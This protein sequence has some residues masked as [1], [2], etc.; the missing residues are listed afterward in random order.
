[1]NN[2]P[3]RP[4]QSGPR[5][6]QP[7]P[8][9]HAPQPRYPD[10][11]VAPRSGLAI[12]G[13][14]LGI[15]AIVTSLL[16]IINNLSFLL[17]ILGLIFS[18]VGLVGVSRGKKRGKGI[19]IAALILNVLT[20]VFVLGS[21]AMYTQAID[22]ATSGATASLEQSATTESSTDS[23]APAADAG[24]SV[25]GETFTTDD[26][27]ARYVE[28]TLTNTSDKD[29]EYVQVSYGLYDADGNKIGDSFANTSGLSVGES[30]KFQAYV[31]EEDAESF[32]LDEVTMW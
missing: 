20:F 6:P 27:G 10:T 9:S 24:Y 13:F 28:G 22:E 25:E 19:A 31:I 21:Q 11:Y 16:P 23:A 26:Y 3:Q 18:I 17:A 29:Y 4:Y 32:E 8:G 15:I 1:M 7:Q 5:T 30:W 2:S 14:V 12:A